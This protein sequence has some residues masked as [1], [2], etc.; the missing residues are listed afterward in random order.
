MSRD[1][2]GWMRNNPWEPWCKVV[3]RATEP[4]DALHAMRV[5][6]EEAVKRGCCPSTVAVPVGEVPDPGRQRALNEVFDTLEEFD[7]GGECE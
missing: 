4:G 1:Y 5:V 7:C 6:R 3:D 2:A